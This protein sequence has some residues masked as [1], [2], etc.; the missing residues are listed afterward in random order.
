[1]MLLSIYGVCM[2]E[3]PGICIWKKGMEMAYE[4]MIAETLSISSNKNEMVSAYTARPTGPGPFHGVV[5]IHHL[6]GWSEWEQ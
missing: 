1:M 5:L 6:P 2:T 4:G 3:V